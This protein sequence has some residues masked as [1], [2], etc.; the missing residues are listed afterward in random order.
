MTSLDNSLAFLEEQ[1]SRLQKEIEDHL[2]RYPKLKE[3]RDLLLTIPGV[4]DKLAVQFLAL[5]ES[6]QFTRAPEAAAFLGLIPVEHDSGTSVHKRPRLS[7]AGDG[8][9]R[10]ALFMPAIVATKYNPDVR[11]LYQRLTK[12]GKTKM[13]AIGAAMR[14]LVHIAFGVFKNHTPYQQQIA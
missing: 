10:A 3:E 11:E 9:F 14:K 1:K 4:G 12:A 2:S 6:K 5:F 8:R 13:A 7:K